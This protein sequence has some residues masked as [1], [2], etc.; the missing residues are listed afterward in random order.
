M[1]KVKIDLKAHVRVPT[2]KAAPQNRIGLL[3]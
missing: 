2:V 3:F 1:D